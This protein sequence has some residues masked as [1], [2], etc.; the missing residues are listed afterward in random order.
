MSD[1]EDE[2]EYDDL[3]AQN[4]DLM[5]QLAD[6]ESKLAEFQDEV[7]ELRDNERRLQEER[8][9]AVSGR[10]RTTAA[11]DAQAAQVKALERAKEDWAEERKR[12]EA[13][14][15]DKEVRVLCAAARRCRR[16]APHARAARHTPALTPVP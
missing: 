8:D 3:Y 9:A 16:G 15:H 11:L 10:D 5:E 14:M 4:V 2:P 6:M 7:S 12:L 13:D 1:G